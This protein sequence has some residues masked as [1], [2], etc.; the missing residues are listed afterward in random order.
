[1]TAL[2]MIAPLSSQPVAR[3]G[4]IFAFREPELEQRRVEQLARI[5]A[6]ERPPGAVGAVLARR[7]ADDRQ[8]RLG[9][10]ERRH[11][12][13]PPVGMLGAAFVP[14]RH[15]P[16]AQRAVARRLGLRDRRQIGGLACSLRR[17]CEDEVTKQSSE[18]TLDCF[19]LLAMTGLT[20]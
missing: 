3:V 8:P 17:H 9:I 6:G 7:E 15:Q 2:R 20:R 1:M 11:R 4:A 10:A 14:E 19:A 12:R 5:I 13:V 16:R 18:R